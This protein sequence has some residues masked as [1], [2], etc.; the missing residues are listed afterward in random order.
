MMLKM[1]CPLRQLDP[2]LVVAAGA[3]GDGAEAPVAGEGFAA[4]VA[5][6]GAGADVTGMGDAY[7]RI[8]RDDG[9]FGP[10][11]LTSQAHRTRDVK[12]V[13]WHGRIRCSSSFSLLLGIHSGHLSIR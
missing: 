3:A 1:T 6:Q 9:A 11:M 5:A 10:E 2:A 12:A 7:L 8:K 4:L 13:Y